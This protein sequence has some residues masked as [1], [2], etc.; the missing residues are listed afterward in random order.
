ML[1]ELEKLLLKL[2]QIK[3]LILCLTNYVTMDFTAN[4]LL[5][6]GAAPVMSEADEEIEELIELS[7]ALYLNIGTLN[8]AFLQ[9]IKH[10]A[11][12][13][14]ACDKPIILDPV[15]CGASQIRTAT[16]RELASF[17]KIIRGNGSEIKALNG[18]TI[19]TLGV[20][21]AHNA[22]DAKSAAINIASKYNNVV[23][24]SGAIDLIVDATK[25]INCSYGSHLM[26]S[27]TGMGCALTAV[28]AAFKAVE[29]DT[30]LAASLATVYFGL[31]GNSAEKKS[32]TPGSFRTHFID[33]LYAYQPF[34]HIGESI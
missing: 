4:C 2:R 20:E 6:L 16:A 22:S 8:T 17:A 3:P 27:I 18:D 12:Y 26:S 5:A 7:S 1:N 11:E 30:F 24:V 23:V 21:T 28:I 10:A 13:A 34:S 19:Q 33:S 29:V 32:N 9:R 25:N 15:G 31:C 14:K